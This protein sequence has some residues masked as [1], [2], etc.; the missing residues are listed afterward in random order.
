MS[1]LKGKLKLP[2]RIKTINIDDIEVRKATESDIEGIFNVAASVGQ[3]RKDPLQ[4]YL[5]D[6]YTSNPELHKVKLLKVLN[7][8]DHFYIAEDVIE[9]S[10][11]VVGFMIA[12]SKNKWLK[13][14]SDWLVKNHFRPDFNSN[15]LEN[16]IMLDK[17][18]VLASLNRQGVGSK[19]YKRLIKV[20]REEKVYDIFEEVIISP[21]PNLPSVLFKTKRGLKLASVRYEEHVGKI[22]T[23]L[24]YHR[25][26]KAQEI[27]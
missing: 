10:R 12:Y 24:V 2:T 5:M 13:N 23:T 11:R 6:D 25:R 18:A 4:G 3:K 17:I 26:I 22:L 7:E 20:M 1:E 8:A 19:L 9:E 16:Y 15:N 21:T 27:I 14:N